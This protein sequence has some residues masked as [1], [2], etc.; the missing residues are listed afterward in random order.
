MR[1]T[2]CR[3]AAWARIVGGAKSAS[4]VRSSAPTA[5][6]D[7]FRPLIAS[8]TVRKRAIGSASPIGSGAYIVLTLLPSAPRSASARTD[9]GTIALSSAFSLG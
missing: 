8:C 3:R 1:C 2:A 6:P 4:E 7:S 9:T 5:W